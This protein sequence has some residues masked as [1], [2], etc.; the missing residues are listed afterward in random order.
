[1]VIPYDEGLRIHVST[2]S[3][4]E[5][6]ILMFGYYEAQIV[7]IVKRY[8]P[9][10]GI[11]IDAGA[12]VGC[13][14]IVMAKS[15]GEKG[16]IYSF[17]PHPDLA[18]RLDANIELNCLT[19]VTVRRRALSNSVGLAKLYARA[20]ISSEQGVSSLYAEEVGEIARTF[21]VAL[22]RLDD[23]ANELQLSRLDFMKIDTEGNECRI[24]LGGSDTIKNFRPVVLFEYSRNGWRASGYEL[25][26]ALEYFRDIGYQVMEVRNAE[27]RSLSG[28]GGD[29]ANLLALPGSH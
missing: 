13:H 7:G 21:S 15:A 5:W 6:A 26:F 20:A 8:V 14:T 17:E 28:F 16:N 18:D 4:I 2:A 11:A 12:N 22:E 29:Y 24:L 10:G 9:D 3:Y 1:M 23:F 25:E 19:N 27:L